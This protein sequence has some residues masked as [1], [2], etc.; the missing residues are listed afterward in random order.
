MFLGLCIP[1]FLFFTSKRV[2]LLLGTYLKNVIMFTVILILRYDKKQTN[3]LIV[4][5]RFLGTLISHKQIRAPLCSG[6]I[7]PKRLTI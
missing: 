5:K 6:K 3:R 4:S 2:F 7:T 1:C